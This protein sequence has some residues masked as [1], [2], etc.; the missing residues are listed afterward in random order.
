[1]EQ[2]NSVPVCPKCGKPMAE[3]NLN[4][5]TDMAYCDNC[6]ATYSFREVMANYSATMGDEAPDIPSDSPFVLLK[7]PDGTE[8]ISRKFIGTLLIG[9][10][11]LLGSVA[12]CLLS[13]RGFMPFQFAIYGG[14]FA[15]LSIVVAVERYNHVTLDPGKRC[16]IVRKCLTLTSIAYDDIL[17]IDLVQIT[18][19]RNSYTLRVALKNGEYVNMFECCEKKE[20]DFIG[21]LIERRCFAR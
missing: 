5:T 14:A 1:M 2:D 11:F 15:L 3:R 6:K 4:P 16:M 8:T 19:K 9:L 20:V 10:I 7:N 18:D 12:V 17:Y 21:H 13:V